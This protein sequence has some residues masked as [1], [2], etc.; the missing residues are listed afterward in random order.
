MMGSRIAKGVPESV[1]AKGED[2]LEAKAQ[3]FA[4][5]VLEKVKG[6]GK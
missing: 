4:N 5:S 2:D 3:A 6:R 1:P